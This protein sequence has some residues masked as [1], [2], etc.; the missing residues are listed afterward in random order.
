MMN[1]TLR[2][3]VPPQVRKM[4]AEF[5][6]FLQNLVETEY[7]NNEKVDLDQKAFYGQYNMPQSYHE[8]TAVADIP[9]SITEKIESFQKKGAISNF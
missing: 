2:H 4:Q 8:L 5:Q 9:A 6:T 7:K 3:I 1:E